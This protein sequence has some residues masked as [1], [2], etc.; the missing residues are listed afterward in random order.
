MIMRFL[1]Y[2]LFSTIS[3]GFNNAQNHSLPAGIISFYEDINFVTCFSTNNDR[4][5]L[6]MVLN[7]ENLWTDLKN[8][9]HKKI[10][11]CIL[12]TNSQILL[13][14]PNMNIDNKTIN[15][16]PYIGYNTIL[17][18]IQKGNSISITLNI[19]TIDTSENYNLV[20][21]YDKNS[22]NSLEVDIDNL[23][24][25]RTEIHEWVQKNNT[26]L[27]KKVNMVLTNP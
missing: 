21:H 13:D 7:E 17:K 10:I 2:L 26:W 24:F 6:A 5:I 11:N 15:R 27:K 14:E 25:D 9:R 23:K 19:S 8:P 4:Y 22:T 18:W 12:R 1:F 16:S 20:D 3:I